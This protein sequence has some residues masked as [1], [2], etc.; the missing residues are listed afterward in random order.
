M[1][2]YQYALTTVAD[3]KAYIGQNQSVNGLWVYCSQ[4]DATAAT[5]QVTS[6]TM[7]LIITGGAQAGTNTLTFADSNK[8]TLSELVI[9]INALTGWEAGRIYHP[10]ADST[11]LVITGALSCLGTANQQ[12][13]K[14]EPNY[15]IE[16]LINAATDYIERYCGRKLLSRDYT[17]EIYWGSGD[18]ILILSQ[19]PVTR[20][21]RV[22]I[23]RADSF[24]LANTSTDNNY[25]TVEVDDSEIRLVVDGGTNDDDTALTLTDYTSID[26]L[27]TAIEALGKGWSCTTMASDT[28]TRDADMLLPRPAMYVNATTQ[29]YLET[30]DDYLTDYRL[31]KPTED[32]NEGMLRRL[33]IWNP[34]REYFVDYTAG[35]TTIPYAL[36]QACIELVKYKFDTAPKD[37][38]LKSEKMGNVYAYE[39]FSSADLVYGLSADLKAELDLFKK[40]VI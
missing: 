16:R 15:L 1:S 9:A 11:D 20:V 35:Y 4:G 18:N 2:L 21:A 12:T 10:D 22:G 26:D 24:S 30:V 8:N 37:M 6:A 14:I 36:E 29:A 34:S 7:V 19:Y 13:L 25:A 39:R 33:S 27:I 3:V 32:R 17:S 28:S 38:G 31:E 23:G 40:L 5:V